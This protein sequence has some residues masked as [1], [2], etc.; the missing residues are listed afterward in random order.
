MRFEDEYNISTLNR[1]NVEV[2][3]PLVNAIDK[4]TLDYPDQKR[5]VEKFVWENLTVD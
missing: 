3:E 5:I 1:K 2:S 4:A